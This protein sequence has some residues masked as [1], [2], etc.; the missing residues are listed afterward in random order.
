MRQLPAH[1]ARQGNQQQQNGVIGSIDRDE[2][3]EKKRKTKTPTEP[4]QA[5]PLITGR[6]AGQQQADWSTLIGR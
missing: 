3:E 5:P 1:K 2:E 6:R 4:E